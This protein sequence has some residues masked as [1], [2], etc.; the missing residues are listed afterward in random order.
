M[1][2]SERIPHDDWVD[3]DLLTKGEAAQRLTEEIE[4]VSAEIKAG[5][6]DEIKQCRLAAMREAHA[7]MTARDD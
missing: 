3:Q 7:A 6:G 2:P 4:A 1:D 5:N